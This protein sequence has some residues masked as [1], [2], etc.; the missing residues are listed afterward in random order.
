MKS[1]TYC[2]IYVSTYFYGIS[3]KGQSIE[4]ESILVIICV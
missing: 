1:D 3:K 4:K 2:M